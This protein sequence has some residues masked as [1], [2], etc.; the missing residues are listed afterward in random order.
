M[1]ATHLDALLATADLNDRADRLILADAL[2]DAGRD[3]EAALL[4][5]DG[6]VI[7]YVGVVV[8]LLTPERIAEL[9]G[10]YA[11]FHDAD[12]GDVGV[13]DYGPKPG[14]VTGVLLTLDRDGR[15]AGRDE[16]YG[17]K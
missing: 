10:D 3:G 13:I 8:E 1:T 5:G 16:F 15:E 9:V 2:D 17:A 11:D 4:R 12:V 7:E 14:V 6:A